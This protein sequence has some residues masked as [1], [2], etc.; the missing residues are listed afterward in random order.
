M[1]YFISPI[2]VLLELISIILFCNAFLTPNKNK[3]QCIISIVFVWI[4]LSLL[5]S[6]VFDGMVKQLLSICLILTLSFTFFT[7]SRKQRFLFAV[8]GVAFV[9]IIDTIIAYGICS[10]IG[11]S[12]AELV[13]KKLLYVSV[14]TIAKLIAIFIA[15]IFWRFHPKDG[16]PAIQSSWLLLTL[17]FPISSLLMMVVIFVS[18]QNRADLSIGALIYGCVLSIANIGILYLIRIMEKRTKEEQSLILLN[19]QMDI[20]TKSILAL[21]K[22]Y[23]SQRKITH[24]FMHQ[25]QTLSDLLDQGDQ[26]A[27]QEYI[28]HIQC[29]KSPRL[30]NVNTHHPIL[31]AILNQKYQWANEQDIEMLLNINDL[32]SI[33]FS[34]DELVVLFSNL[35]DNAIEACMRLPDQRIIQCNILC[36]E[37]LYISIR[38]T[39]PPVMI[40]NGMIET[41]KEPKIEHG[42]GLGNIKHILSNLNAEFTYHYQDGWFHF[43]AEVPMPTTK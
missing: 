22:S 15:Y 24:E 20:Q 32:S 10:L 31:D 4:S 33:S 39:S 1:E 43:V 35:F 41:S 19:Q 12:F 17:L 28:R 7:G 21:E 11:I 6:I 34:I 9:G 13:W 25:I 3:V 36:G 23:R 42:F 8:L 26:T 5:G 16:M 18:F 29:T 27:A 30:L 40:V 38:N 14:V 37:D 2:W